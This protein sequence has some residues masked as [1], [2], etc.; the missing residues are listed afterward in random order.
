MI[1]PQTHKAAG[2]ASPLHSLGVS[3]PSTDPDILVI[4]GDIIDTISQTTKPL[5]GGLQENDDLQA[6][7]FLAGIILR[8]GSSTKPS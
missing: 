1:R 4:M 5:F 8:M 6:R 2:M 3:H 7:K